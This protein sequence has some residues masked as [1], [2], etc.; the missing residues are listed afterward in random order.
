MLDHFL[1]HFLNWSNQH[2]E[3]IKIFFLNQ[4]DKI[5]RNP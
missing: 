3:F 1:T 2:D 4:L 5:S